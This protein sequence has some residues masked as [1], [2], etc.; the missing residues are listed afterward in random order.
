MKKART[1]KASWFLLAV[2]AAI[3]VGEVLAQQ[4]S[5]LAGLRISGLTVAFLCT[6]LVAVVTSMI[7]DG[8]D[9]G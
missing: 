6:G 5:D 4:I 1:F 8:A 9:I 2:L 7:Y 3:V